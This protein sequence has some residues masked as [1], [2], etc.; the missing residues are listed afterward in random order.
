MYLLL[1]KVK[2][3]AR[4]IKSL[5]KDTKD[6]LKSIHHINENADDF[7]DVYSINFDVVNMYP[8]ISHDFGM[9]YVRKRLFEDGINGTLLDAIMDAIKLL[10]KNN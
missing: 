5:A 6:Y 10:L 7:D 9:K 8:S 1:Q 3:T 2:P 4:K